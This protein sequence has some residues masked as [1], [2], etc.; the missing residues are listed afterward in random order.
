MVSKS[1][2]NQNVL[3]SV[4]QASHSPQIIQILQTL[5]DE[6]IEIHVL[7]MADFEM[8]I[9]REIIAIGVS[10]EIMPQIS[11]YG[12]IRHVLIT[13]KHISKKRPF[14]VLASGQYATT[15]LIPISFLF[16]IDKR[17]FIRHHSIF[18]HKYS[19]RV[20]LFLD[21]INNMCAT[22]VVAVSKIVHDILIEKEGVPFHKVVIIHNGINLEKFVDE[23]GSRTL[24]E[25]QPSNSG[26]MRPFTVGVISRLTDWKGVEYIARA[27]KEFTYIYPNALLHIT[28][29]RAD[30]YPKIRQILEDID[31]SKYIF[32]ESNQDVP[33]LL[34]SLDVFIHTPIGMEDEAFGI[35]YIEALAANIPCVFT[36]S[37][38][39]HELPQPQKHASIVPYQDWEAILGSLIEIKERRLAFVEVPH[40]WLCQFSLHIQ[41]LAYYKLINHS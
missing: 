21:K 34:K 14:A 39:L 7:I 18:H 36:L 32:E 38:I 41:G 24:S 15:S 28:G 23:S 12:I 37:G 17:I 8:P 19:F 20:G 31:S 5:I 33:G 16:G 40:E 29:A 10:Y 4:S 13:L 35:V 30:S 25:D 6:D 9:L 2:G 3:I 22:Q 26:V 1:K 11:K 27:F